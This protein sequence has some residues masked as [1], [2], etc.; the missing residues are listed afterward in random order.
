MSA[1]HLSW[2]ATG[3]TEM[4]TT[5]TLRFLNSPSR[6]AMV[7]S[8]V[9]HTGVKFLGWLNSTAQPSPIHSWKLIVPCV[10][11][12]VKS[13]AISLMRRPMAFS[14]DRFAADGGHHNP[15]HAA[16]ENGMVEY[17]ETA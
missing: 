9:V 5:L 13:G 3:S 1:C 12:A 4:P 2:L 15:I 6:P 14:P 7:P 17:A 11:S 16:D 8:S 10:V